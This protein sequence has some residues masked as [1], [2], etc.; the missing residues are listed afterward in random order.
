MCVCERV[1][2]CVSMCVCVCEHVCVCERVRACVCA[3]QCDRERRGR[4][5]KGAAAETGHCDSETKS[6]DIG[7]WTGGTS[8]EEDESR[9]HESRPRRAGAASL[10]AMETAGLL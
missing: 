5:T 7:A 9:A 10:S 8:P 4:V 1:C 2:V 3:C 6:K